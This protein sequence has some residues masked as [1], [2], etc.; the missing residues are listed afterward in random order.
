MMNVE[1]VAPFTRPSWE[2]ILSDVSLIDTVPDLP[3]IQT[4]GVCW[5]CGQRARDRDL[6]WWNLGLYAPD[7]TALHNERHSFLI[8]RLDACTRLAEA[9]ADALYQSGKLLSIDREK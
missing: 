4:G 5:A 2:V 1:E 3:C 7:G 9:K 8:H 6:I